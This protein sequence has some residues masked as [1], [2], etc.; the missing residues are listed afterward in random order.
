MNLH[1]FKEQC[2][3]NAVFDA[4]YFEPFKE[5]AFVNRQGR[6]GCQ[7]FSHSQVFVVTPPVGLVLNASQPTLD[8]YFP[9]TFSLK[10]HTANE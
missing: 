6:G 10:Y 4:Y 1:V 7:G 2:V 5:M 9:I 8:A 3:Y